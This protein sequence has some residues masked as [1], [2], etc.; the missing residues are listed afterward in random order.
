MQIAVRLEPP[1]SSYSACSTTL[2]HLTLK[3]SSTRRGAQFSSCVGTTRGFLF[4]GL[5]DGADVSS[6]ETIW[7]LCPNWV[8]SSTLK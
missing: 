3:S 1:C 6:M 4:D 5:R 8:P 2:V 7:C